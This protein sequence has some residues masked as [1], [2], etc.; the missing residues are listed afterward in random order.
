MRRLEY[1]RRIRSVPA[2]ARNSAEAAMYLAHVSRE[3]HRLQ[4][5]RTSLEKRIRRIERQLT[6]IADAEG[7]LVPAI[8]A[9]TPAVDAVRPLPLARAARP[10]AAESGAME[11]TLQY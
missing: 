8:Q 9:I 7:K 5:E 2:R 10:P 3:R 6:V 1:T 4:Q 11:I